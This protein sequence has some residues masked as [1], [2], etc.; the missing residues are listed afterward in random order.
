MWPRV[1]FQEANR[2]TARWLGA[3]G[4]SL[5]EA[6]LREGFNTNALFLTERTGPDLGTRRRGDGRLLADQP[7]QPLAAQAVHSA[8]ARRVAGDGFGDSRQQPG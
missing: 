1:E 2:A 7:D 3:Q 4:D 8:H 6:A 5:R